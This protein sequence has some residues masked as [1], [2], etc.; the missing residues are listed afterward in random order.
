MKPLILF[1]ILLLKELKA[2]I[3]ARNNLPEVKLNNNKE[4]IAKEQFQNLIDLK[5]DQVNGYFIEDRVD[6]YE[7]LQNWPNY[8]FGCYIF[9]LAW[10]AISLEGWIVICNNI[11][12]N[13]HI[14]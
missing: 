8:K 12:F 7:A 2:F 14:Y 13:F 1:K 5:F 4:A 3:E 11:G 9:F 6:N 10:F